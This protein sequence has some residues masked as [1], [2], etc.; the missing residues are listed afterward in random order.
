M[1]KGSTQ[2]ENS[3]ILNICSLNIGTPR[4]R[5]QILL[6]VRE[7]IDRLTIIVGGFNTM[8]MALDRTLRQKITKKILT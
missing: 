8:L 2:S 6:D 4:F 1:I 3:T 5:K 7:E